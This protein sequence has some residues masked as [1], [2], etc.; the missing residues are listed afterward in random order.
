M[1]LEFV[2]QSVSDSDNR[3]ADP[4]RLLNCYRERIGQM[5]VLKGVLGLSPH[6]QVMGVFVRALETI[7]EKLYA[8]AGG[9]I[10]EIDEVGSVTDIGPADDGPRG[11]I[12]SNNGDV[13]LCTGGKYYHWDGATLTQP[14]AG[15]FS[16]FG[17]VD[18]IGG[19]TMLTEQDGIKFQW[20][21]LLDGTSLP[22]LS[23][24]SADGRDDKILRGM[25]IDGRYFIF[26]ERS[27][28]IWYN[29]GGAG[30]EA[31][32]RQ[33]GGVYDVGLKGVGLIDNIPGGGAFFIGNDNRA[34]IIGAPQPVSTPSVETALK[35]CDPLYCV[36]WED[37]GHTF[38]AILFKDCPAWVY[39]LATG[40]WFERAQ[41]PDFGPW[42]VS[43]TAK[44]GDKWYA[45]R[46]GGNIL[47]FARTNE[48]GG[49]P[50]VKRA[51]SRILENDGQRFNLNELEFYGRVGLFDSDFEVRIS[52]DRGNTFGA[53]RKVSWKMG[54]YDR[55]LI[56]RAFG[57]SRS[58][59]AEITVSDSVEF[60]VNAI[61]RA[62]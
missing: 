55:R 26:K 30:A 11:T 41:W 19:Y 50:L 49:L 40:E 27:H 51:I 38:C 4:S 14:A 1:Q 58:F 2:G 56:L 39:D 7:N 60:P 23:F 53:P 29:T 5:P 42:H 35:E 47:T 54:E 6:S 13:T 52:K 33:A 32:L 43:A 3:Q 46:D 36:S 8:L 21:T 17:S 37:E 34:R 12:S 31:F 24:A 10:Y 9:R 15:A 18:Y 44:L 22:G 28:E 62:A 59:V 48:D 25:A 16:N 61:V 45:A 20:S 57:I